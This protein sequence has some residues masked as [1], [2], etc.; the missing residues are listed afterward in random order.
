MVQ[1][2]DNTI[3]FMACLMYGKDHINLMKTAGKCI[4]LRYSELWPV[5]QHILK[6]LS[7]LTVIL[8]C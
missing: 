4:P 3:Y 1:Q 8:R 5:H 7:D 6:E 2:Y